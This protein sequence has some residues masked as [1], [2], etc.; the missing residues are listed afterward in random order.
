MNNAPEFVV[1]ERACVYGYQGLSDGTN[2]VSRQVG[3]VCELSVDLIVNRNRRVSGKLD[4]GVESEGQAVVQLICEVL[5][6]ARVINGNIKCEV[7]GID[8][9]GVLRKVFRTPTSLLGRSRD[10]PRVRAVSSNGRN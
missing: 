5:Q 6:Q 2:V 7:A 9:I 8:E 4:K 10:R 3:A 1:H